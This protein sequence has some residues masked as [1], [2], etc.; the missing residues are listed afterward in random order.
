MSVSSPYVSNSSSSHIVA[1]WRETSHFIRSEGLVRE[2]FGE[3]RAG[4]AE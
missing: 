2:S 4:R 1:V 3:E